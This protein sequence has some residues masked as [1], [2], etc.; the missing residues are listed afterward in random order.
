MGVKLEV[1]DKGW[2]K[3]FERA[4]SLARAGKVKVGILDEGAGAE[5]REGGLTNAQIG[6]VQE[7]GTEDKRIPERSFVRATFDETREEQVKL[8]GELIERVLDGKLE[9]EQA[10]GLMGARLANDIK[11][12]VTAGEHIQPENQ[13]S[14]IQQKGSDRPL[15]DTS[16]MINSV[17]WG[18][19]DGKES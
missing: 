10:T 19:D 8:A 17:T 1:T 16:R 12:K 14:T 3:F 9:A 18:K 5:P 6:V 15:V 11:K 7:F 13:P 2:A 4:F